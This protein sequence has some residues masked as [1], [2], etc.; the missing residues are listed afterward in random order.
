M[1]APLND[2]PVA[3]MEI[4]CADEPSRKRRRKQVD[5]QKLWEQMKQE[6]GGAS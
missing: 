3:G 1:S 6:E 4:A 2:A 5:Y